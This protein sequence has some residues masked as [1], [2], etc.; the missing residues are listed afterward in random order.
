EQFNNNFMD[1]Q[2]MQIALSFVGKE[3]EI[4]RADG[5]SESGRVQSYNLN[6]GMLRVGN[7]YFAP[8]EITSIIARDDAPIVIERTVVAGEQEITGNIGE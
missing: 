6:T 1:S 8:E 2:N 4:I 5:Q 3:V 7:R